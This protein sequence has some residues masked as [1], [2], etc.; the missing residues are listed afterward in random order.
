MGFVDINTEED[1]ER[2]NWDVIEDTDTEFKARN[3]F[4]TIA[5]EDDEGTAIVEVFEDGWPIFE[6]GFYSPAETRGAILAL[7]Q[8]LMRYTS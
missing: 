8:V 5:A 4:L 6:D 7:R 1:F 3:G 2:Y